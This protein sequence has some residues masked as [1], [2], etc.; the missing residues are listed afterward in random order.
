MLT[1]VDRHSPF[2]GIEIFSNCLPQEVDVPLILEENICGYGNAL[3]WKPALVGYNE[4]MPDYRSC[5]D[6]KISR[7]ISTTLPPQLSE[8][9]NSVMDIKQEAVNKYSEKYQLRMDYMEAV[10][11]VRY[12]EG[13]HFAV[14]A[15]HGFSY[16][17]TVSTVMYLNDDYEGG[18]LWFPHIDY[19]YFPKRGD[20]I[21][22]P[23]TY[24]YAHASL[25][26]K[27]GIKYSAVTMFDYNDRHHGVHAP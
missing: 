15:D 14:H 26:V 1:E 7:Q 13:D 22:F 19:K 9:A 21:I 10:N 6:F 5:Y 20:L 4:S 24:V 8:M 25:P 11:F 23:S 2:L 27:S 18:E 3:S 16:V 12:T 17:C